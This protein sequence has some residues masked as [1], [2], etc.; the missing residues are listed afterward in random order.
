[1]ARLSAAVSHPTLL[2]PG[3]QIVIT[4]RLTELSHYERC[5]TIGRNVSWPPPQR[6]MMQLDPSLTQLYPTNTASRHAVAPLGHAVSPSEHRRPLPEQDPYM[7]ITNLA[8]HC[9]SWISLR[10]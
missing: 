1:M 10:L 8:A 9:R 7:Y 3:D 2:T 6:R 4:N 5:L